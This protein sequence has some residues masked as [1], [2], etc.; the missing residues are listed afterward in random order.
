M[1]NPISLLILFSVILIHAFTLGETA[2][3]V[4]IP[5]VR[6][7]I[8]DDQDGISLALKN[9]YKIYALNTERIVMEGSF[10]RTE[11]RPAKEGL[12]I[13]EKV[14]KVPGITVKV[15]KTATVFV[16]DKCF[17]GTIDII[18]KDNG[19]FLVVN[20]IQLEEYLYGVLHQE[21]SHLWPMEA[22]KAQAIAARTFALYEM[23]Q[24]KLRDYDV[25]SDI[26]S[27]VY[28]GRAWERWSTNRA[29]DLTRGQLLTCRSA[30]F[31]TYFHA[32][33]A[34]HT[35]DASNLWNIDIPPLK[36][37]T[38]DY[39]KDSP[40]SVWTKEIPLYEIEN[41][42]R[43][44]KYTIGKIASLA[45]IDRNKIGRVGKVEVKDDAGSSVIL[46]GKDFRQMMGP[47]E[48]RSTNFD[49][50]VKKGSV[51]VD[52]LGWG[53]GVGMCQWGAYGL[54]LA[55]KKCEEILSFYY[56]GSAITTLKDKA[57]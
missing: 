9:T 33:C 48:I 24:S 56:P 6:V 28:G 22:L 14:V 17:R 10:L 2:Q 29:V 36:G 41:K 42:L 38:C 54:A 19:K 31:P 46:T 4:M 53:H 30:L 23:Q 37:V 7:N 13:G 11:V 15:P 21:V 52:G 51:I 1:R 5:I 44:S 20:R 47:N 50:T 49:F 12:T 8:E 18:K 55:G 27:Q 34:G 26:Y 3:E 43:E 25:R 39:C 57:Q 45:V 32:T 16:N 35:E 40:H